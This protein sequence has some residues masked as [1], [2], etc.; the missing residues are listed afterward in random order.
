M[1]PIS[2]SSILLMATLNTAT[3]ADIGITQCDNT[4]TWQECSII[5]LSDEITKDDGARFIELTKEIKRALVILSGPGG[6][7]RAGVMIGTEVYN[8][9]YHTY[10]PEDTDCASACALVW[11]AGNVRTIGLGSAV[12][13]HT[14]YRADDPTHAD[15][16]GSV[17]Q[18]IYLASLGY[19]YEQAISLFGHGPMNVHA[20]V[21]T[22]SGNR[23]ADCDT[24]AS[25]KPIKETC[26]WQ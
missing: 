1:K 5:T 17:L 3:A 14:P 6:S 15:G 21:T 13:F 12:V 23:I 8:K 10:V 19:S 4:R 7:F 22:A 2:I 11:L 26:R 9:K 25:F 20:Y 24:D 18:G 16:T